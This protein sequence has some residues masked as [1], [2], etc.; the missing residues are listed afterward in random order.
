MLS[1]REKH[2]VNIVAVVR[3]GKTVALGAKLRCTASVLLKLKRQELIYITSSIPAT[4][5]ETK[6]RD[7]RAQPGT[8]GENAQQVFSENGRM[9]AT[10]HVRNILPL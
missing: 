8:T 9:S 2:L 5:S 1:S 10:S 3:L 4:L 6:G 7:P